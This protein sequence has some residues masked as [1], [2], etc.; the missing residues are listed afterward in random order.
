M[1]DTDSWDGGMVG[2]AIA[3]TGT[4]AQAGAV[5]QT[6]AIAQTGTIAQTVAVAQTGAIAQSG[7]VAQTA[8]AEAIVQTTTF[9]DFLFGAN[10]RYSQQGEDGDL[11]GQAKSS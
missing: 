1:R 9:G 4:I 2:G 6:G 7:A 10:S 11:L 8:V 5:A 3:Q